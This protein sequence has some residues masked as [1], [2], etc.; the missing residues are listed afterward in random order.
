MEESSVEL[1][2]SSYR[3]SLNEGESLLLRIKNETSRKGQSEKIPTQAWANFYLA[4][5]AY[6][7][8]EQNSKKSKE[9]WND[10][11]GE[12]VRM[13]ARANLRPELEKTLTEEMALIAC[14]SCHEMVQEILIYQTEDHKEM[15][16]FYDL[17]KGDLKPVELEYQTK[18][19]DK[20][21]SNENEGMSEPITWKLR[22]LEEK[23][24]LSLKEKNWEEFRSYVGELAKLSSFLLNPEGNWLTLSRAI[25]NYAGARTLLM[26]ISN[27]D[28]AINSFHKGGRMIEH[29]ASDWKNARDFLDAKKGGSDWVVVEAADPFLLGKIERYQKLIPLNNFQRPKG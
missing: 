17:L 27:I 16:E 25:E 12:L 22:Q 18:F 20:E 15:Q 5:Y 8:L 14:V 9:E 23:I 26:G 7:C 28:T 19:P 2:S 6:Q 1:D 29:L 4:S 24:D 10:D 13:K 11:S 3:L 21:L